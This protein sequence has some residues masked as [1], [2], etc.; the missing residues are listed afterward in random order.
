MAEEKVKGMH[1]EEPSEVTTE[2]EGASKLAVQ[3][4][5]KNG[6]PVSYVEY[7]LSGHILHVLCTALGMWGDE[8]KSST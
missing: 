1:H 7:E 3:S 6:H 5:L 4:F 8:T 2:L